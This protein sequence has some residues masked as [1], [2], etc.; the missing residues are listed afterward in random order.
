MKKSSQPLTVALV[1]VSASLTILTKCSYDVAAPMWDKPFTAPPTPSITQIQPSAAPPGVNTIVI[2]GQNLGG[3]PNT[4]G[5]YFGTTPTE[6]V[7]KSATSVTVRRPALETDSCTVK[8]VSDSAL[9]VAKVS[10]G[11]ID[12]VMRRIG[13]FRDNIML[14][15]VAVDSVENLYVVSG[16]SPA[17]IWKVTPDD[18]RTA[19]TTSGSALR[20]PYDA[21]MRGDVMYLMSSNREIQQVNLATGAASR[22]TQMPS[23]KVVRFGDFDAHG[24]FYTGGVAGCDL[25]VVPPNPP[26]TLTLAQ[27]MVVGSYATEEILS[28]RVA[29]GYLYVA[30]RSSSQNPVKIWRHLLDTAGQVGPQEPVLDLGAF[31]AF[32]S[33][34]VKGLSF[35]E[36]GVIYLTTDAEEPLLVFNPADNTLDY[37]YKAIIPPY[38]KHADWGTGTYLYMVSGDAANADPSLRWNIARLDVGA[39][40]A[41]LR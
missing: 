36:T 27:I 2:S 39:R 28:I 15:V 21:V 25:C 1:L 30:S 6:V 18:A 10:F 19:L 26:A 13:G 7:Q 40:G 31:S 23:G 34:V 5:V 4:D 14:A 9:I 20:P 37:F 41:S 3:V 29:K 32:S 38:G 24:Y 8:L 17:T 35:S 12:P 11:K 22:W 16:L 33:R